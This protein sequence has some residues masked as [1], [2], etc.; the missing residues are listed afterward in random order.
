MVRYEQVRTFF[1][2]SES[3]EAKSEVLFISAICPRAC[4]SRSSHVFPLKRL[5][6]LVC[7]IRL[8][9]RA[10]HGHPRTTRTFRMIASCWRP[11]E[12]LSTFLTVSGGDQIQQF[13][14]SL[15]ISFILLATRIKILI[16]D[17]VDL[18]PACVARWSSVR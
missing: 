6:K 4:H 16:D 9:A 5:Q 11:W 3:Q 8:G 2:S 12:I 10:G 13:N 14:I 15:D 17:S 1:Y 7:R 18:R